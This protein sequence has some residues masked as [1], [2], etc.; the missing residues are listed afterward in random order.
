MFTSLCFMTTE[1]PNLKKM[2][3][4]QLFH[5]SR[6]VK[7]N[8]LESEL[9]LL[10]TQFQILEAAVSKMGFLF[11]GKKIFLVGRESENPGLSKIGNDSETNMNLSWHLII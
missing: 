10:K 7:R 11:Q 3:I 6:E 1:N 8:L 5:W 9:R 2:Q 4:F